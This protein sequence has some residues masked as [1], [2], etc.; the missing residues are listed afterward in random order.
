[1]VGSRNLADILQRDGLTAAGVV[2]D[3]DGPEGDVLGAGLLDEGPQFGDIHIALEGV[4]VGRI[5]GF[6]DHQVDRMTAACPDVALGGVKVHIG[7][8]RHAR[9]DQQGCQDVFRRPALVGGHKMLK[10]ED[11]LHGFLQAED[12]SAPRRRIH[13]RA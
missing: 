10:T 2:G 9:L 7:G 8:D 12:T 5:E 3:G 6:I 4:V 13:R 11:L 1:M